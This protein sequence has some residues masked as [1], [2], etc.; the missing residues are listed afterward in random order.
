MDKIGRVKISL[1]RLLKV[2]ISK[3]DFDEE[4]LV[5]KDLAWFNQVF[6][7]FFKEENLNE[8]INKDGRYG[9][10]AIL[11]EIDFSEILESSIEFSRTKPERWERL[12]IEEPNLFDYYKQLDNSYLYFDG[13]YNLIDIYFR[14]FKKLYFFTEEKDLNRTKKL[15]LSSIISIT[16]KISIFEATDFNSNALLSDFYYV[17]L[18]N[19]LTEREIKEDKPDDEFISTS[20]FKSTFS[21]YYHSLFKP[22]KVQIAKRY[23]LNIWIYLKILKIFVKQLYLKGVM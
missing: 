22:A 16:Q 15:I 1:E 2:W 11:P 10:S 23:L 19:L 4:E 8:F 21:V 20:L 7:D 17:V 9:R 13:K 6:G 12:K 3:L 5:A 18:R 14:V